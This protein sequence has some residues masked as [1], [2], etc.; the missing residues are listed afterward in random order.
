M[1]EQRGPGRLAEI[2]GA[3]CTVMDDGRC[4]FELTIG[5][6]HLNPYGVVHGGI[7]YT[8]VDYAMGG[9]M[10]SRLEPGERCATLEVKINYLAAASS[11]KMRAEAVLV[12]RTGR[13]GVLQARV[14]GD[15]GRL[16][17]L[18]TGTFYIRRESSQ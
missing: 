9:A 11:G 17:A 12:E 7:A 1:T 15:D 8:L 2:L 3:R 16:L 14:H 10:F 4:V 6:D 5:P 18:A 13:I